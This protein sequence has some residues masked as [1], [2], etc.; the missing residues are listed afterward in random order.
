MLAALSLALAACS[1]W[2]QPRFDAVPGPVRTMDLAA[3]AADEPEPLTPD[4]WRAV[5]RAHDAYLAGFDQVRSEAIAP[6]VRDARAREQ[7]D[8]ERDAAFMQQDRKSVV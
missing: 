7:A 2:S 3:S 1:G 6:L 4:E 5:D 8:L